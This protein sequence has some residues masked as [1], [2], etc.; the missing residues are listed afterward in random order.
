MLNL[1]I[2]LDSS[3]EISVYYLGVSDSLSFLSKG[4]KVLNSIQQRIFI[5]KLT[6]FPWRSVFFQSHRRQI[7]L[8]FF[9]AALGPRYSNDW[10][11]AEV[12]WT[13]MK[14]NI[15]D[16][17]MKR[18]PVRCDTIGDNFIAD[19]VALS[20]L[21]LLKSVKSKKKTKISL[22]IHHIMIRRKINE[23]FFASLT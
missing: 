6:F 23:N 22:S 14:Q 2:G 5:W 15:T 10:L 19:R 4:K 17:T 9:L 21:E 13:R 7:E 18:S 12:K 3:R 11:L 1:V 20:E 16:T 8:A